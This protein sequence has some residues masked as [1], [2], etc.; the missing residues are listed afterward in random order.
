MRDYLERYVYAP[1]SWIDY[2][3]L[4]GLDDLLDAA[5]RGRSIA[6]E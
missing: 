5:R 1:K 4:L 3:A 2:L 6:N